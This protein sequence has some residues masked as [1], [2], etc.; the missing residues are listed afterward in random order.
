M[1]FMYAR[2]CE[3]ESSWVVTLRPSMSFACQCRCSPRPATKPSCFSIVDVAGSANVLDQPVAFEMTC[4]EPTGFSPRKSPA[5]R[6]RCGS[7]IGDAR[8]T[9]VP[10]NKLATTATVSDRNIVTETFYQPNRQ[11]KRTRLAW[12]KRSRIHPEPGKRRG[13][14]RGPF[15]SGD[16]RYGRAFTRSGSRS[17][18]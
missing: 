18:R 14:S 8:A 7:G 11:V 6:T 10:A 17:E 2:A 3:V 16:G 12:A 5:W 15:G 4:G 13:R 1:L 9:P